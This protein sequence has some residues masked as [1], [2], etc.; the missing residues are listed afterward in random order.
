VTALPVNT[1]DGLRRR[2]AGVRAQLAAEIEGGGGDELEKLVHQLGLLEG[3]ARSRRRRRSIYWATGAVAAALLAALLLR[4]SLLE[5][6]DTALVAETRAFIVRTGPATAN[7]LPRSVLLSEITAPG[8]DFARCTDPARHSDVGCEPAVTLRLNTISL[9]AQTTAVIRKAGACVEIEVLDGG[10]GAAVSAL[11]PAE[12]GRRPAEAGPWTMASL[13]LHPGES[14]SF[15]PLESATLQLRGI[16]SVM[17]GDRLGGTPAEQEDAPSLAKGSLS[18]LTTSG[19]TTF[20]ETDIPHL[21]EL[22]NGVAIAWLGEPMGLSV[23]G[24]AKT[25]TVETGAHRRN[26]MPSRLDWVRGT[27][28]LKAALAVLAAVFGTVVAVRER[29]LGEVG[30]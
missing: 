9:H 8:Q 27:P 10:A 17:V 1:G 5:R 29:W 4:F 23:V 24:Q 2:I 14:F 3:L 26:L 11:R 6:V 20:R 25:L 16:T 30:S 21:G 18:I 7:V 12:K 28:T 13:A 22:V 15:C 19:S